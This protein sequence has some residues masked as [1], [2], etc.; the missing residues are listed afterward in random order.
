MSNFNF[1]LYGDQIYGLF[2]GHLNKY[3]SPDINK[4]NFLAMFKGGRLKYENLS[5]KQKM[6]IYPQI[7]INSLSIKNLFIDIPDEKGSSLKLN[8]NNV[9]CEV[10]I[11]NI[12]ENQVK[13]IL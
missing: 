8:L 13:D 5:L 12:T 3:I 10:I 2:S 7:A 9:F 1:R 11:T 4:E 6:E